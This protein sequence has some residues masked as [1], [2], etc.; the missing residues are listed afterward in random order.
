MSA[1]RILQDERIS[2][3]L[4]V[5]G[6]SYSKQ[7]S[8]KG[9]NSKLPALAR[10]GGV[11]TVVYASILYYFLKSETPPPRVKFAILVPL[12]YFVAPID[13]IFD[14]IPFWGLTD[15]CYV[16][17]FSICNTH[18]ILKDYMT[19][20]ILKDALAATSRIF[21]NEPIENIKQIIN[22]LHLY[23]PI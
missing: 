6:E 17:Y 1:K 11:K 20:A 8:D 22:N 15:D 19:P 21:K 3:E 10:K 2:H 23:E 7:F 5:K 13:L 18:A 14:L 4:S 9:F 12:G 16:L